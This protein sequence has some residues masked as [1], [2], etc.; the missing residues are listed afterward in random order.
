MNKA[1]ITVT[2][3]TGQNNKSLSV[4]CNKSEIFTSRYATFKVTGGGIT[5]SVSI[6][7]DASPLLYIDCGVVIGPS[8]IENQ[9]TEINGGITM[10]TIDVRGANIF[11][12]NFYN[13]IIKNTN[14]IGIEFNNPIIESLTVSYDDPVK[15]KIHDL[16][17]YQAQIVPNSEREGNV[18]SLIDITQDKLKQIAADVLQYAV[19]LGGAI[20][21]TIRPTGAS[22]S[23]AILIKIT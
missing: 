9:V 22:A 15:Y 19:K 17:G 18:L 12:G 21:I 16:T 11:T 23:Y 6:E 5:K 8:N 3:D 2:P 4:N 13:F 7:Q 20:L 14:S 10:T 1:F